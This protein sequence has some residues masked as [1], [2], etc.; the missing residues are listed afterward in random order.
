M[1]TLML[2]AT[3]PKSG[4]QLPDDNIVSQILTF[5]FA[6]EQGEEGTYGWPARVA[7]GSVLT[8]WC[9]LPVTLPQDT[10]ARRLPSAPSS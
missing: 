8:C 7:L 6:G 10:T 1:L 5:L 9:P 2:T 4:Q 3:D